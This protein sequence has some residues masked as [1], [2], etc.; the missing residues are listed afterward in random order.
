MGQPGKSMKK[1]LSTAAILMAVFATP[2]MAVDQ[3]QNASIEKLFSVMKIDEQMTGGF[4]AMLPVI[5]NMSQQLS[6]NAAEKGE[7]RDIYR[8]WFD[9]D[10]D[11]NLIK[12]RLVS[13]YANT[14]S[15]QEIEDVTAFYL[16][17]TGQKFLQQSPVLMKQAAQIGM[18]E[19]QAKQQLLLDRLTPFIEKHKKAQ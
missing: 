15:Q 13:L 12:S 17:P 19:A 18:M 2:V 1:V 16:T 3:G 8:T 7:L 11:R 4:E 9:Q 5:E 10:I 14:Y 6:L